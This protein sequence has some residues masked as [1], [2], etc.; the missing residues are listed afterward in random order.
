MRILVIEDEH[1]AADYIKLGLTQEAYQVDVAYEGQE[2]LHMALEYNYD[3]IIQDIMLPNLNGWEILKKIRTKNQTIPIILLTACDSIEDR[4]KGLNLGA[5]DYL[6]KPFAFSELLARVQARLRRKTT[7][8][9]NIIKLAH[10]EVDFNRQI[11]KSAGK[12]LELSAKEFSLLSLLLHRRGQ[13]LS[14][15]IIAEQV[16]DINFDSDTNIIDVAI[17]RLRAKLEDKEHQLIKTIRGR[18]YCIENEE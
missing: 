6:V 9:S 18:G 1:K 8:V 12:R 2:G 13:V 7:S 10:L 4:V 5:D 14:R 15:T 11:V 16:W 3:L 17:K